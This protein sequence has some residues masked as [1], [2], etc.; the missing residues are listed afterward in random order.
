MSIH[1]GIIEDNVVYTTKALARIILE[2]EEYV[3][4]KGSGARLKPVDA[5]TINSHLRALKCPATPLGRTVYVSGL[6]F[7]LAIEAS[8]SLEWLSDSSN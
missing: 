7:R 8:A 5:E 2:K 1:H 3:T 6:H 4:E